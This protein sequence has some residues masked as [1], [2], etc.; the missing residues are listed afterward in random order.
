MPGLALTDLWETSGAPA[1][2]AGNDDAAAR[3][4][5]LEPPA[6][7]TILRIV[8]FPPDAQ[9]R[10]KADARKAFES[11]SAAAANDA[12]P[13]DSMMHKTST[14]NYIIIVLKGEIWAI[15]EKGETC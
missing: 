5:R 13:A 1:S 4:V 15:M 2:N 3:P 11:I 9:W 6:N 12:H 7:G 8:E 14:V 10:G